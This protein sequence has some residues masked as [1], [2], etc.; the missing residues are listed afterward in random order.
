[1]KKFLGVILT[2]L[3]CCTCVLSGCNLTVLDYDKFNTKVAAKYH[4]MTISK[5]ELHMAYN[6]NGSNYLNE[7]MSKE[8]AVIKVINDCIDRNLLIDYS[9]ATYG[10]ISLTEKEYNALEAN[11][12]ANFIKGPY[13]LYVN[14]NKYYDFNSTMKSIYDYIN[15]NILTFENEI[16]AEQDLDEVPASSTTDE[17]TKFA[18]YEV[19]K[20]SIN[21]NLNDYTFTKKV[22]NHVA[23]EVVGEFVLDLYG[24]ANISNAA[25][26]RY[27]IKIKN[28]NINLYKNCK[29]YS[30]ILKTHILDLYPTYLD[31]RYA[32]VVQEEFEKE[33]PLEEDDILT[34]YTNK[35]KQS[36]TKYNTTNGYEQYVSDM[37]SDPSKVFW[38]HEGSKGFILTAHVLIKFDDNT[39][40][41]LKALETEK[42]NGLSEKVY[43]QKRDAILNSAGAYKRDVN[44]GKETAEFYTYHDIYEM[45]STDLSQYD[46]IKNETLRATKKAEAFNKYVYMFSGDEGS[47]NAN[48]YYACNLDTSVKDSL[49][50]EYANTSREIYEETGIGS[51][52]EPVLVEASNYSGYHIILVVDKAKNIVPYTKIDDITLKNLY[53][54]RAMLG[55][56]QKTILDSCY[57]SITKDSFNNHYESLIDSL[58][59]SFAGEKVPTYYKYNYK[60]LIKD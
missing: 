6:S 7:G 19:Y 14:T 23:N 37:Q 12:K 35:V 49:V 40:K 11:Q 16:R 47:I 31:N 3:I 51:L 26:H 38:H 36:Y 46:Y 48:H 30:E 15:S 39:V 28:S 33:L 4:T 9:K 5:E 32:Q 54:T 52:S 43:N 42:E 53:E 50:P 29:T 45:I 57:D 55:I 24:S 44:T 13:N 17:T 8:D 59:E 60:S 20:S 27:L 34:Y 58:R 21:V 1:M 56:S 18:G 2:L 41:K 22:D 25:M 10:T